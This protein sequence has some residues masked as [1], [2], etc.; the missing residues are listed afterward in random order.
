[1][2]K[3]E[4]ALPL[5]AK[6]SMAAV[7]AVVWGMPGLVGIASPDLSVSAQIQ[8]AATAQIHT[9]LVIAVATPRTL[10][11]HHA[12]IVVAGMLAG[13]LFMLY[14]AYAVSRQHGLS[15]HERWLRTASC[16]YFR[17]RTHAPCCSLLTSVSS[18]LNSRSLYRGDSRRVVRSNRCLSF[19]RRCVLAELAHCRGRLQRDSPDCHALPSHLRLAPACQVSTQAAIRNSGDLSSCAHQHRVRVYSPAA[20]L[21]VLKD[22]AA[23][24]G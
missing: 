7:L 6:L 16:E 1:M 11:A 3:F 23:L 15:H 24:T 21:D 18:N 19:S 22:L 2:G 5:T 14:T 13:S 12:S 8:I 4:S 9:V 20:H 10:S 17:I